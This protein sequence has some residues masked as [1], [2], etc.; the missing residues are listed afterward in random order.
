MWKNDTQEFGN[1]TACDDEFWTG[2]N[3]MKKIS[4]AILRL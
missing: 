1:D 2:A 3:T 4:T